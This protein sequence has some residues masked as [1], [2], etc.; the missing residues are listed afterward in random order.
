MS[1][2]DPPRTGQQPMPWTPPPAPLTQA[3]YDQRFDRQ[4]ASLDVFRAVVA[5]L[6]DF[7]L[8]VVLVCV[9]YYGYRL[10]VAISEVGDRLNDFSRMIGG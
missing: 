4:R 7:L 9:L 8:I 5:I 10:S 6:R 3:Q 1:Y 2:I